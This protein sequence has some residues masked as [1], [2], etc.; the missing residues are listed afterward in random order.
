M[1]DVEIAQQFIRRKKLGDEWL[2]TAWFGVQEA[3]KRYDPARGAWLTCAR[4]GIAGAIRNER[5][6]LWR[7]ARHEVPLTYDGQKPTQEI[8]LAYSRCMSWVAPENKSVLLDL[9][10]GIPGSILSEER[11]KERRWA[12]SKFY[13]LQED[14]TRPNK[15]GRRKRYLF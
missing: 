4:V 6:K 11:G 5:R 9:V 2:S 14:L 12:I 13:R 15:A 10:A 8:H 7:Y 3:R 1:T